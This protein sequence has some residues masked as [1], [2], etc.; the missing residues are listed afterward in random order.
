ML[1]THINQI[2]SNLLHIS[3]IPENSGHS[4][5]K[6]TPREAFIKKILKTHLSEHIGFGTGE[7]IDSNSQPG[8]NRNQ[9]DLVLYRKKFPKIDFGGDIN[10]FLAESVIATIE[11]KSTLTKKGLYKS[12]NAIRCAKKLK[13]S[14]YR[15]MTQGYTPPNILTFIIAYKGPKKTST[16]K[17]WIDEYVVQNKIEY[18]KMPDTLEERKKVTCPLVDLIVVLGNGIIHFD[19]C[20]ITFVGDDTRKSNPDKKWINIDQ[21]KGDLFFLFIYLTVGVAG[22]YAQPLNINPYLRN[23][24][25]DRIRFTP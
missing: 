19:N 5:H 10:A 2:E 17:K 20:P 15:G 21:E 25:T 3:K 8:E 22:L 14:L 9:I 24:K 11:V 1:I 16:I 13:K 6:G 12:F 7:I 23:F 4:L 18:P